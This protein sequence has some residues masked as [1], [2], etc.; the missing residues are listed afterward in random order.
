MVVTCL[1]CVA[2]R[3]AWPSS[4]QRTEPG[5][6]RLASLSPC[7]YRLR[8]L[9]DPLSGVGGGGGGG[10]GGGGKGL[11]LLLFHDPRSGSPV[12]ARGE[13]SGDFLHAK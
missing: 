4:A 12:K 5:G 8:P 1:G 13:T 9:H 7:C 6:Q 3:G 2:G 11:V 10:A